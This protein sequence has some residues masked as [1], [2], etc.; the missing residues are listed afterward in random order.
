MMMNRFSAVVLATCCVLQ[1]INALSTPPQQQQCT[2]RAAVGWFGAAVTLPQ[3]CNAEPVDVNDF[4]KSGRV[5][6][7]MGVSGQAGKSRPETGVVIRDGSDVSR[8][9]RTGDV[10]AEIVVKGNDGENAAVL[11]SYSSPWPLGT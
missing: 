11:A 1:Q 7:P 5:A 2:R 8:D 6:M 3:L 9:S 10:L 4:L